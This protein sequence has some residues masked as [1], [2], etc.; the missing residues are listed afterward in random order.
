M[1]IRWKLNVV[2]IY[3]ITQ[4]SRRELDSTLR[5]SSVYILHIHELYNEK[6]ETTTPTTV[7]WGGRERARGRSEQA[8]NAIEQEANTINNMKTFC[9]FAFN[10]GYQAKCRFQL[11]SPVI[12]MFKAMFINFSSMTVGIWQSKRAERKKMGNSLFSSRCD[13]KVKQLV[14]N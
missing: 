5:L 3:L 12:C 1:T 13:A 4:K 6:W 11:F 2:H 8:C 10:I 14:G 9:S 7:D